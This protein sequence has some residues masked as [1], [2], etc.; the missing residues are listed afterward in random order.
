M[1]Y[2]NQ[3]RGTAQ[4]ETVNTNGVI[5]RNP[6][7]KKY[8][9]V[10]YWDACVAIEIGVLTPDAQQDFRNAQAPRVRQV[11]SFFDI[12]NFLD[13]CEEIRDSIKSSG[14]FSSAGVRV[15]SMKNNIISI[16]NGSDIGQ[17]EGIY[18]VVYKNLDQTNRSN[19]VDFYPFQA[20][21]IIREYDRNTGVIREDKNRLREFK[22]F[23]LILREASKAFT[24]A[25]AHVIRKA[26]KADALSGLKLLGAIAAKNGVDPA[27]LGAKIVAQPN[28]GGQRS[29]S[30]YGRSSGGGSWGQNH[31]EYQN[32]R[33]SN[34]PKFSSAP[35]N[36][37]FESDS[38]DMSVDINLDAS[39]LNQVPF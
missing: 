25:Q 32:S 4:R 37:P 21:T 10:S 15:G 34:Q 18:L 7:E 3:G 23:V 20:K 9:N 31:G 27:E 2:S 8:M 1:A 24:N 26:Q 14:K 28:I 39:Q 12:S 29:N 33:Y 13:V 19:E 36:T 11:F 22:D 38:Q 16:S 6:E 35:R 17:P 5:F 30:G